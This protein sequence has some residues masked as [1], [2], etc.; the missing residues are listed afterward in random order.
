MYKFIFDLLTD[1]LGLPISFIWEYLILLALNE[2]AFQI[3]WNASPGG[4]FGSEIHWAVRLPTFVVLWAVTYAIISVVKWI[5]ANWVIIVSVIGAIVLIIGI[6][7]VIILY[8][9]RRN[10]KE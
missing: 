5:C 3:A 1:P 6:V 10:T 7:T 9:R 4:R 8:K 2:I